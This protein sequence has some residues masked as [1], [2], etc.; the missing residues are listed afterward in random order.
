MG[1]LLFAIFLFTASSVSS[2][3]Y[4]VVRVVD[5]DTVLLKGHQS[6]MS[7]DLAYIDSPELAWSPVSPC[8]P[9]S[10]VAQR[11]LEEKLLGKRVHVMMRNRTSGDGPAGIVF[12][13]GRNINLELVKAGLAEVCLESY[14]PEPSQKRY[15][16]A[17]ERAWSS[18]KGIWSLGKR[19]VCPRKWRERCKE[20]SAMATLLYIL[21]SQPKK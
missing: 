6:L 1:N 4:T 17:Q 7:L 12:L 5:G 11:Y 3:E 16:E 10:K 21:M 8:Q 20:R 18:G 13:D 14:P 19:Y 15:L 9:F 2:M